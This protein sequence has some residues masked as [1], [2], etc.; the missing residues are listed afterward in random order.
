MSAADQLRQDIGRLSAARPDGMPTSV[1]AEALA[2]EGWVK[3]ESP[4]S[5][6]IG[7]SVRDGEAANAIAGAAIDRFGPLLPHVPFSA[8]YGLAAD[9]LRWLDEHRPGWR[10]DAQ[11]TE[12][13]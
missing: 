5:R 4:P 9:V 3:L 7:P 1:L 2:A 10:D 12:G 8:R 13:R 11:P 6:R